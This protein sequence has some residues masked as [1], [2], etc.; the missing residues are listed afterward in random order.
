MSSG[1]QFKNSVKAWLSILLIL[2]LGYVGVYTFIMIKTK[3]KTEK[4]EIMPIMT[5][6]IKV[7]EQ[8]LMPTLF[9]MSIVI[10]FGAFY[11]FMCILGFALIFVVLPLFIVGRVKENDIIIKVAKFSNIGLGVLSFFVLFID[12]LQFD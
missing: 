12:N 2:F 5:H 8:D 1:D 6:F 11:A 3:Y 7:M 9:I 10:V 4:A